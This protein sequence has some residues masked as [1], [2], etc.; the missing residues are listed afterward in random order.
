MKSLRNHFS[1][2][3]RA[4]Q[5]GGRWIN[6]SSPPLFQHL[7]HKKQQS[8]IQFSI[9]GRKCPITH[10]AL[11]NYL[12][13]PSKLSPWK[14]QA[15]SNLWSSKIVISDKFCQYNYCLWSLPN[16]L[17]C[18][19]LLNYMFNLFNWYYSQF[20]ININILSNV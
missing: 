8:V 1:S 11:E 14:F 4:C 5:N 2:G 19:K 9:F 16:C 10:L 18:G 7:C 15:F 6:N 17:F 13:L 20:T 12:D 3:G